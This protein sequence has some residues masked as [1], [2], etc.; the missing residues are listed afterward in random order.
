ML[1]DEIIYHRQGVNAKGKEDAFTKTSNGMKQRKMT[2]AG[3]QLC[4]QWKYGSKNWVALKYIK[5]SYQV[6]LAYYSRRMNI[7]DEPTFAC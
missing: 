1:L 6:E 5:Q 7:D 2:K 3:W 4:I